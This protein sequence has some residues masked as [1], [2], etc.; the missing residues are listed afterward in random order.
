[1]SLAGPQRSQAPTLRAAKGLHAWLEVDG[2]RMLTDRK[3]RL[4]WLNEAARTLLNENGCVGLAAGVLTSVGDQVRPRF[5]DVLADIG[6]ETQA[7]VAFDGAG[8]PRLVITGRAIRSDSGV[9]CGLN[10]RAAH[11]GP[12]L[13][14]ALLRQAFGLTAAEQTIVL[15]M[16]AGRKSESIAR[17]GNQSMET[18]RTHIRHIYAKMQINSREAMFSRLSRYLVWPPC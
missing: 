2:A 9:M 14:G 12:S 1:M 18:V 11:E 6:D 13:S 10:L 4:V 3:G 8:E 15:A 16:M 7:F 5:P 17:H